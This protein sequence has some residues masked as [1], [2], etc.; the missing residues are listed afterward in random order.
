MKKVPSKPRRRELPG[1]RLD[2]IRGGCPS[3]GTGSE[4][5]GSGGSGGGGDSGGPMT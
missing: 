5:G 3:E 2:E 1:D 4:G